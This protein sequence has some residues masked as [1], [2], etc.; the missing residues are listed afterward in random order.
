VVGHSSGLPS[1]LTCDITEFITSLINSPFQMDNEV[2]LW[3]IILGED[4]DEPLFRLTMHI[5]D[6]VSE[7]KQSIRRM[8]PGYDTLKRPLFYKASAFDINL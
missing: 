8:V 5:D 1:V 7:L 3:C 6:T 4:V 2:R